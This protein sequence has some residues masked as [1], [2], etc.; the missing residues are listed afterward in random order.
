MRNW[1]PTGGWA[2]LDL[3]ESTC[4]GHSSVL[5]AVVQWGRRGRVLEALVSRGRDSLSLGALL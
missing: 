2:V 5:G 1:W 3:S 4:G